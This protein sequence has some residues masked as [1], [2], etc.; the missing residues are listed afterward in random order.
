[1]AGLRCAPIGHLV[2]KTFGK[3]TRNPRKVKGLKAKVKGEE[4]KR[5]VRMFEQV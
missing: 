4:N 1:M 3:K 2:D 5:L